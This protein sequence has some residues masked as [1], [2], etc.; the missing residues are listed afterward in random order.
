MGIGV[1]YIRKSQHDSYNN[2]YKNK[3]SL[4]KKNKEELSFKKNEPKNY[5][6]YSSNLESDNLFEGKSEHKENKNE[7][8]S[9]IEK[10][11]EKEFESISNIE[12]SIYNKKAIKRDEMSKLILCFID[13]L[14]KNADKIMNYKD[15]HK[16]YNYKIKRISNIVILMNNI[17]QIKVFEALKKTADSHKKMELYEK[18]V[19]EIEEIKK[20]N[21]IR[22]SQRSNYENAH[23]AKDG[24]S[25]RARMSKVLY[26][27]L[28]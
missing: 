8:N 14:Y 3:K 27:S 19:N 13:I 12:E 21:K 15:E 5:N 22:I 23:N 20:S 4:E 7:R 24:Y 25:N 11:A 6:R 9:L 26:K 18:L 28:K 2:I 10:D 17:D 1:P 16:I